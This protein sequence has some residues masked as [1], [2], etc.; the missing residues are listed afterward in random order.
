MPAVLSKVL[1]IM[2]DNQGLQSWSSYLAANAN[3]AMVPFNAVLNMSSC[4]AE[5]RNQ[6]APGPQAL[7]DAKI[8][9]AVRMLQDKTATNT[10]NIRELS[11]S[12]RFV[13]TDVSFVDGRVDALQ[14]RMERGDV[15]TRRLEE[16]VA[17]VQLTTA[18]TDE[19]A[20][21]DVANLR[22]E[23]ENNGYLTIAHEHRLMT[24]GDLAAN[25]IAALTAKAAA[26]EAVANEANAQAAALTTEMAALNNKVATSD[27]VAHASMHMS[28]AN[29]KQMVGIRK[30]LH[31][32]NEDT[33]TTQQD[34]ETMKT[35]VASVQTD[36][37]RIQNDIVKV[38]RLETWAKENYHAIK[39]LNTRNDD[40]SV[41]LRAHE[42]NTW[43][44]NENLL[45]TV[46]AQAQ[47]VAKL[48]QKVASQDE[49]IANLNQKVA[50]QDETIATLLSNFQ[51]LRNL[52]SSMQDNINIDVRTDDGYD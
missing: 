20:A 9:I 34:A 42:F 6:L 17:D 3:E 25:K 30:N 27:I 46:N 43:A 51:H 14:E 50:S 52:V 7:K 31:S 32:I 16:R 23:V 40:L 8:P 12:I 49:T 33:K 28:I 26:T 48:N 5:L 2:N 15:R 47:T 10:R 18:L 4:N 39:E 11:T 37:A 45:N 35:H 21:R 38:P 22:Q 29:E 1:E 13:D 19:A 44:M 24:S 41:G 36:V